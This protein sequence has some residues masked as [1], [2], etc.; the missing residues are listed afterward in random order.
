ME[1]DEI[2]D[3]CDDIQYYIENDDGTLLNALDGDDE[4]EYEF[5]MAFAE[6]SSKADQLYDALLENTNYDDDIEQTFD[7]CTVALIGNRYEVLW[8]D[9]VEEDYYALTSFEQGLAQTESGK[10][11]MR[12]TKAEML[13]KIG[14][15][16]GITL[17]FFDLRHQYDYLKATMDILRDE[18]T[19]IL[20]TIKQ[21]D[22]AY[23]AAYKENFRPWE[24][25]TEIFDRLVGELP[26]RTWIE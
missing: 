5:K 9:S 10:R 22:D 4:A 14:Q 18:N 23:D 20:R 2:R 17:A 1:L 13:S 8:Y 7:D 25:A 21:I 12:S 19:S 11:I 24:N 16:M 15:C 6:V 3:A 26:E